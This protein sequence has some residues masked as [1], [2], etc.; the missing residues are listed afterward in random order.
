[1]EAKCIDLLIDQKKKKRKCKEIKS[2]YNIIC[3]NIMRKKIFFIIFLIIFKVRLSKDKNNNYYNFIEFTNSKKK[4]VKYSNSILNK[5]FLDI[6]TTHKGKFTYYDYASNIKIYKD[7][8]KDISYIPITNSNYILQSNQI[9]NNNFSKLCEEGVLLDKTKYKRNKK[10]KISVVIPYY[11]V[12]KN[13]TIIMTLRSIQNQSLKDFEIIIV[14]DGSLEEKIEEVL[15]EMKNDNRIILLRH[16]ERKGTLLTRVDGIRYASGKYIIQ[17]D[18]DDMYLNNLLFE[19]LYNKS[20]ELDLDLIYFNYFTYYNP[21][22]FKPQIISIPKNVII[23]QPELRTE[24]LLKGGKNRLY[25]CKVRMIWNFFTRKTT[26]IEA[27]EDLGDE[28]MNHI[29]RLYEDTLMMFE[30]TQVAY[31]FYYYDIVG[32]RHNIFRSGQ[33]INK[34]E[35]IEKEILA[36]NQLLFI[37][38]LLYK[39]DP[40]YDRYHIYKELGIFGLC[41]NETKYLNK[42]DFDLGLEVVE[43]VFELERIYKNTAPELIKCINTIKNIMK[44]NLL[45][46]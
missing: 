32:Y 39:I 10:P 31:S 30:L 27:I 40:K 1:M 9:S 22:L 36:M 7:L 26:F 23:K 14:D 29:F 12:S 44:H 41:G 33:S 35:T 17:I 19:K 16:K 46:I 18:Q 20:K 8:Y 28:Y 2:Y 45:N 6:N 3:N 25:N 38:L 21:K 5:G 34:N 24:F 37:K 4:N 11:I 13:L 42:K 43:A 15:N